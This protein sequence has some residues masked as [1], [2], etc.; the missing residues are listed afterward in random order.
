V[1]NDFEAT[2]NYIEGD[3]E[4][5]IEKAEEAIAVLSTKLNEFEK[6]IEESTGEARERFVEMYNNMKTNRDDLAS[7]LEEVRKN[8]DDSWKDVKHWFLE[9]ARSF[10]DYITAN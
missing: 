8:A 6:K 2:L 5:F 10:R 1:K 4:T 9:K 7:K 3:R